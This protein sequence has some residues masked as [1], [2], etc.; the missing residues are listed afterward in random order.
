MYRYCVRRNNYL[1]ISN[2]NRCASATRQ[3]FRS[4][5]QSRGACSIWSQGARHFASPQAMLRRSEPFRPFDRKCNE[6]LNDEIRICKS[7]TPV[8]VRQIPE[9][10]PTGWWQEANCGTLYCSEKISRLSN[11]ATT[12]R[13]TARPGVCFGKF[14]HHQYRKA[15]YYKCAIV[16]LVKEVS[17]LWDF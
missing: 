1:T 4:T 5:A 6:K 7:V 8:E 11:L 2:S 3:Q 12:D 14:N 13:P 17:S 9:T 15:L 10:V 16:F